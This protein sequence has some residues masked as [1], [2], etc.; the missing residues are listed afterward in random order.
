MIMTKQFLHLLLL[1]LLVTGKVASGV[2][3]APSFH[4]TPIPSTAA[5]SAN[6]N[7]GN[8]TNS[9]VY[10]TA[11]FI[12]DPTPA[13][14]TNHSTPA[15]TT[16]PSTVAPSV[17]TI[18]PSSMKP[19][20][21]SSTLAPSSNHTKSPSMSPSSPSPPVPLA[22]TSIPTSPTMAPSKQYQPTSDAPSVAPHRRH[23][24]LAK[25][26]GKTIGWLILIALSTLLFGAIMS[27][28]YRMYYFAR[29]VWYTFISLDCTKRI[30][31]WCRMDPSTA[32]A[33]L[34]E[35]IFDQNDLAEGL[36][37]GDQ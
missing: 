23:H 8:A 14:S 4:S 34:N 29:G 17:I 7:T 26:I 13:P 31:V 9:P 6:S 22:P 20:T 16:A 27:N 36:L 35:I 11:P 18:I 2:S 1:L 3:V 21:H 15:V 32:S 33:S 10:T 30:M 19:S 12:P 5:P 28:R 24:T 37:M 25:T